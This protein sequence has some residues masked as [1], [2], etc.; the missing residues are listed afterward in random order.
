MEKLPAMKETQRVEWKESWRDESLKA[1]C[2]FANAEG[3]VLVIGRNDKGVAV[4]VRDARKLLQ[5]IPN[6]VRDILGIIVD[7]DLRE[8][9]RKDTVEVT[10]APYDNPINYKGEYYYRSG[11]TNQALKGA[12]LDRFLMRKVGRHW[13]GVPVP[14]VAIKDLSR[15]AI[16]TFRKQARESRRLDAAI[17]RESTPGLLDKLGA[18]GRSPLRNPGELPHNWTLAK[19]KGKH[20]SE[21]FNPDIANAFF[22][23]GE[24]EA[25]GR[26]IER[27]FDA[28]RGAG[29]PAPE[30]RHEHGGLWVEFRF[31]QGAGG[32]TTQETTQEKI[33]V[34]L[35]TNPAM[36]RRQLVEK[37]SISDSGI[38]YHLSK[39]KSSGV[40]RHVGPTKA[41]RWE[42]LK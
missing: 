34:M 17:L 28:C 6:K 29:T 9:D 2:G 15:A 12:A 27:V 39:L 16:G 13:D 31:P 7:V 37:L 4:G 26:G 32:G 8:I 42:V 41:G 24:I 11:S 20:P 19:L 38:K 14:H 36:T 3:G 1:I 5:D 18:T 10:V 22:R 25:W 30:L 23:A 35:K 21:P 33:L 40:L